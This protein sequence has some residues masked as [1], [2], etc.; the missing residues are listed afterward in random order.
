[1]PSN[2]IAFT[3]AQRLIVSLAALAFGVSTAAAVS[4]DGDDF[5]VATVFDAVVVYDHDLTYKG[6]LA[7]NVRVGAMA[8]DREGNLVVTHSS[9]PPQIRVY[10]KDGT[11][12]TARSFANREI[13]FPLDMDVALDGHYLV[14]SQSSYVLD[15]SPAGELLGTF[16]FSPTVYLSG[17]A[18]LPG[19]VVWLTAAP[20]VTYPEGSYISV[21]D[22]L[23][24][25]QVGSFTLNH[26]QESASFL[27]Y[28]P[29]TNTVLMADFEGDAIVERDTA[30]NYVRTFTAD[31]FHLP[32]NVTRGPG[33]D[34]FS[35]QPS[36]RLYRWDANGNFLGITPLAGS[37]ARPPILWAGNSVPEP[38][39]MFLA[40]AAIATNLRRRVPLLTC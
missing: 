6:V 40:I 39:A 16:E 4:F 19:G 33:G 1:M 30:G 32:L 7:N 24:H 36:N 3:F 38:S 9:S 26:G 35:L 25:Q 37:T 12:L 20:I 34:V 27:E 18:A 5:L 28:T 23:T 21:N 15:F 22:Q 14:G 8:L 29:S 17:V 10:D 13:F 2:V 11:W 31:G